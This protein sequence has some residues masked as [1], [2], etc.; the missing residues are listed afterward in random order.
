MR[1]TA[2]RLGVVIVRCTGLGPTFSDPY[3]ALVPGSVQPVVWR[4]FVEPIM[5]GSGGRG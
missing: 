2:R 1:G 4:L 5:W 3:L